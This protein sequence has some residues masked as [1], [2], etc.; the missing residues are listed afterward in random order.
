VISKLV[1]ANLSQRPV[2]T[3]LSVLL[4]A[5]PV[6]LMLTLVGLSHGFVNDSS[7]R[8]R[9][10]GADIIVRSPDSHIG[11]VGLS[12]MPVKLID[13][14]EKLPHV[15][16]GTGVASHLVSGWTTVSGID[17]PA[18]ERMSGKFVF[19]EGH[20]FEKPDDILLDTYYAQQAHVHA[21][22]K[23]NLLNR[24]WNL[25]GIVEPGK[26]AHIFLPL[27]VLQDLD[28][29]PGKVAQIYLKLDNPANTNSVIEEIK[30]LLPGYNVYGVEE[31]V[32][33]TSVD[34]VPFLR[35]LLNVIIGVAV[36][37]GAAVASL[38]MYMAVQQ[39]T[40]EIGILKSLGASKA[41]VLRIILMEA[42]FLGLG[43][44]ILGVGFS[45]LSRWAL[46][47]LVPASL[48]QAIVPEWW[49]IAGA[50]AMGAAILGALY[51]GMLAARQDPIQALAYE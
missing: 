6:T 9:G 43:G 40:R 27:S 8:T 16:F 12:N 21:G 13:R 15:A 17:P 44:S 11:T 10:I 2:R 42:L 4:I 29:T 45:F 50:I 34:N 38:S 24:D 49:P 22:S 31:L 25:A 5:I 18:F 35:P 26:L 19:R 32:S 7:Q 30:N 14:L 23:I 48:P 51:P 36:L 41:L 20:S 33:L 47:K 37:I 46:A 3:L 28:G 39:R 1:A